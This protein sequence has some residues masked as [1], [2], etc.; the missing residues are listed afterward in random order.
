MNQ[1]RLNM[2]SLLAADSEIVN[3]LVDE[4]KSKKCV[5]LRVRESR[6]LCIGSRSP[7]FTLKS[8]LHLQSQIITQYFNLFIYDSERGHLLLGCTVH[9]IGAVT[10]DPSQTLT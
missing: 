7:G 4:K 10:L 3:E 9:V 1:R 2:P 5:G 8:L 6:A